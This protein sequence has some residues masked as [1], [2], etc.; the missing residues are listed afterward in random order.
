MH[1]P[2][3]F[4]PRSPSPDRCFFQQSFQPNSTPPVENVLL[5]F[6]SWQLRLAPLKPSYKWAHTGLHLTCCV[7]RN[8]FTVCPCYF[9]CRLW[10]CPHA[11]PLSFYKE[12]RDFIC[13]RDLEAARWA[14]QEGILSL[15]GL[16]C[17]RGLSPTCRGPFL[18]TLLRGE[19]LRPKSRFGKF[20]T[21]EMLTAS[22]IPWH[23]TVSSKKVLYFMA[24]D[25]II[26][27]S[28]LENTCT[29]Q[30]NPPIK[31]GHCWCV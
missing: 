10:L 2:K 29:R 11:P 27:S 25:G 13:L 20:C 23:K 19:G 31:A 9:V 16:L 21:Q 1:A 17:S 15:W 14:Q 24:N 12:G 6:L 18:P 7:Q 8:V 30:T 22:E 28:C 26:I 5:W 3:D 4:R